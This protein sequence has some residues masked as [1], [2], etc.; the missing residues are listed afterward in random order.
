MNTIQQVSY[1]NSLECIEGN[2]DF[3]FE[4]DKRTSHLAVCHLL[5][6]GRNWVKL[7]R[8]SQILGKLFNNS[9]FG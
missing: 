5:C 9:D 7:E 6:N 1:K 8:Q 3:K 4:N 2:R